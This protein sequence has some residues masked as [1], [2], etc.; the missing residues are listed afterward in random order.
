MLVDVIF[1]MACLVAIPLMTHKPGA[2]FADDR[3]PG[4]ARS[5]A[6]ALGLLC[7]AWLPYRIVQ[8]EFGA[9]Q[10][11]AGTLFTLVFIGSALFLLAGRAVVGTSAPGLTRVGGWLAP[12]LLAMYAR[13]HVDRVAGWFSPMVGTETFIKGA[14]A[15]LRGIP[16]AA[17]VVL[18]LL[19]WRPWDELRRPND[20]GA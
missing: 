2:P 8:E 1:G 20:A 15:L 11:I 12:L 17:G 6:F 7:L 14:E 4:R 16:L 9:A 5:V 10:P 13:Y 3:A 19:A 18:L